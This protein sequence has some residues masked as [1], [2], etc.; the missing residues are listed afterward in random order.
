[1]IE[2]LGVLS[3]Q[4]ETTVNLTANDLVSQHRNPDATSNTTYRGAVVIRPTASQATLLIR[5]NVEAREANTRRMNKAIE[6]GY[7]PPL[8][9]TAS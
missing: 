7:L 6:L 5:P 3:S 1:M 8:Q 9:T 2:V 4:Q